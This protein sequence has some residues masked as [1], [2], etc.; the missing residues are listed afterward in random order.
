VH[1][2]HYRWEQSAGRF[3][4]SNANSFARVGAPKVTVSVAGGDQGL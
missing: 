2:R 3:L 4:T 1:I